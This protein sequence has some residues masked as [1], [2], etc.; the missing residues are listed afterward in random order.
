MTIPPRAIGSGGGGL[1]SDDGEGPR[2]SGGA[3]TY[4]LS[5][6]SHSYHL[7]YATTQIS[8]AALACQTVDLSKLE[9][10]SANYMTKRGSAPKKRGSMAADT[11]CVFKRRY[12][13]LADTTESQETKSY[14]SE[15]T[16]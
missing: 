13:T 11:T 1:N 16:L 4:A 3:D 8:K 12:T 5:G 7:R 15:T 2:A 9:N 10:I 6:R 14:E